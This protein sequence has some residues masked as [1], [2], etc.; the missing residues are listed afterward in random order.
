MVASKSPRQTGLTN[1]SKYLVSTDYSVAIIGVVVSA[2][3][4]VGEQVDD[5]NF[6]SCSMSAVLA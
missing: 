1:P 4:L 3:N 2:L 5:I 6:P